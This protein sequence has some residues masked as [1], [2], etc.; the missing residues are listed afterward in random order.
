MWS[1][2]FCFV[3][4]GHNSETQYLMLIS[5]KQTS[6]IQVVSENICKIHSLESGDDQNMQCKG[7]VS[8][9]MEGQCLLYKDVFA[10]LTLQPG[11]TACNPKRVL[12]SC[13]YFVRV[14]RAKDTTA[15]AFS[16]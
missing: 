1:K 4:A 14:D 10:T 8:G 3:A 5:R 12:T 7:W 9:P 6:L 13:C 2:L 16:F 11:S 15:C